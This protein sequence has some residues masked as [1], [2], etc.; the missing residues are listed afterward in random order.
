[1]LPPV[2]TISGSS[3]SYQNSASLSSG[4]H[5][6]GEPVFPGHATESDHDVNPNHSGKLNVLLMNGHDGV[7]EG[8]SA[9]A[10]A[11]GRALELPRRDGEG[12]S[13]YVERLADALANLPAAL[14]AEAERQL[15]Q[16]LR[17]IR[18]PVLI[19]AFRNPTGPEAARIVAVLEM[20]SA[21]ER[22]LATRFVLTSYRQ[23]GG[24]DIPE[25]PPM[26]GPPNRAEA[27]AIS[28]TLG[29][30]DPAGVLSFS[31]S[32]TIASPL[33]PVAG[34]AGDGETARLA[35][36][37]AAVE[38]P[39]LS[40]AGA[41]TGATLAAP[42]EIAFPDEGDEAIGLMRY[43]KE[44]DN[45]FSR[46]STQPLQTARPA[47]AGAAAPLGRTL[48]E[49]EAGSPPP[50]GRQT[51]PL[52]AALPSTADARGLQSV[53]DA[54]FEAGDNPDPVVQAKAAI[55]I[56]GPENRTPASAPAARRDFASRPYIDY[57]RPPPRPAAD[58]LTPI[59]GLKGWAEDVA[60]GMTVLPASRAAEKALATTLVPHAGPEPDAQEISY[61][62]RG[63]GIAANDTGSEHRAALAEAEQQLLRTADQAAGL[64]G[65]RRIDPQPRPEQKPADAL[66]AAALQLNADLRQSV[67]YVAF[68]YPFTAEDDDGPAQRSGYR[69][70]G[71]DAGGEETDGEADGEGRRDRTRDPGQ[72]SPDGDGDSAPMEI[73]DPAYDLYQRMAGWS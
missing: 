63:R 39:A 41:E 17:G 52:R 24:A 2:R 58:D 4:G 49:L 15:A 11:L 38:D 69:A 66:I 7:A 27:L 10:E 62:L 54:A 53:L 30:T 56:L 23:N 29:G 65:D 46:T 71:D 44:P 6:H 9:I 21:A 20:A 60:L 28:L 18:L 5:L 67:A 73:A 36:P 35:A 13:A 59:F 72:E 33:P 16:V 45:I 70:S 14:R 55:E 12:E 48:T 3:G 61:Q 50:A 51:A 8:L 25:P 37:A 19:A 40:E 68:P 43:R 22:D 57:T 26:Q 34:P 42:G 32:A 64:N 31:P 1:M 47:E